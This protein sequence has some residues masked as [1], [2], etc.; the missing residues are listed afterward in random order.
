MTHIKLK[1]I[2]IYHPETVVNNSFY[3]KHY[4]EKGRDATKFLTDVLGRE[5]RY[6]I[7]QKDENALTMAIEASKRVLEQANM[8][9]KDLDMIVFSSQTPEYTAPSNAIQLHHALEAGNQTMTMD[10]NANCAGMTVAVDQAARNMLTNPY[11]NTILVVGSDYNSLMSNHDQEITYGNFG[12][13]ACAV[14]LE[15][16][17]EDTGFIDSH[18]YVDSITYDKTYFPRHGLKNA[19]LEGGKEQSIDWLPF[20]GDIALEPTYSMIESVLSRND[21]TIDD[22]DA[23]CL[24]QFS[25]GNINRIQEHFHIE[26]EKIMFVGDRFGYTGTSSPFIALHEGIKSSRIKR[27]DNILFWTIGGGFQLATMLFKY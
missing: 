26:E 9:G 14:I 13:A 1:E 10:S 19:I 27:G 2:S 21:M 8:T 22:I 6:I 11:V 7:D 25:I 12:D 17:E 18:Y 23:F 15:K 24:S 4:Q 5:N 3:M 16:T 20:D